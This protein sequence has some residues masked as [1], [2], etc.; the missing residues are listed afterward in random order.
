MA[1]A[2]RR[3]GRPRKPG[4][5]RARILA[6]DAHEDRQ[7]PAFYLGCDSCRPGAYPNARCRVAPR[8]HL[9]RAHSCADWK[10]KLVSGFG[11]GWRPD[12][13]FPPGIACSARTFPDRVTT[14][15]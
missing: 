2:A 11:R 7:R 14:A 3:R 6:R 13:L 5:S 10:V 8:F 1:V 9:S 15:D 12:I 4:I